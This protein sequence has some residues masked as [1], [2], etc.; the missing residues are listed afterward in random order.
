MK[1]IIL[2]SSIFYLLG[3]K[4][5]NTVDVI[6]KTTLTPVVTNKLDS[7]EKPG[8]NA[9]FHHEL[10]QA[11][12]KTDPDSLRVSGSSQLMAPATTDN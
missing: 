12:K 10:K 7:P 5:S 11:D 2:V 9:R 3:L 6:K 8:V 1:A 4:I